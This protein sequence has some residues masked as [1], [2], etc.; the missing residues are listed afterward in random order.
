MASQLF[1]LPIAAVSL[2]DR[3]RQWFKSRVGVDHWQIPR[4]KAPC[5][6]VAESRDVLV[7]PDL[8]RHDCFRNSLLAKSG[9]RFYAGAPLVT[10]DGYGLGAM[11]VLGT[12]PREVTDEEVRALQDLAAMVMAQIELQHAFGRVDP[13]S[14][15]P[16]R[17]Q[18]SDDLEDAARDHPGEV[19]AAILVDMADVNELAEALRVV[20]PSYIDDLVKAATRSLRAAVPAGMKIYQIANTQYAFLVDSMDEGSLAKRARLFNLRLRRTAR[21]QNLPLMMEPSIGVAP[22]RLGELAPRDVLRAAHSAA[23][24]ARQAETTYSVYSPNMDAEHQRR[25]TILADMRAALTGDQLHLVYQP[26]IDVRS[27][28]C[29]AAEA[30]LR[31]RHPRLGEIPPGEFIPLIEQTALVRDVTNWVLRAA[32][33]QVA[34]WRAD[35]INLTVS[36]NVSAANLDEEGFATALLE[37]LREHDLPPSSL[38]LELTESA[39]IRNGHRALEQLGEIS[40]AGMEVAIDDFGTGYSSLSYLQQIP[41]STLKI[42]RSFMAEVDTDDHGAILVRAMIVMAH[43]LGYRVVAEGVETAEVR[44]WLAEHACDEMQGYFF[45][46]PLPAAALESWLAEYRP[47]GAEPRRLQRTG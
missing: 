29:I 13:V 27:G 22:F 5:A 28:S 45:S 14:G 35:G 4:E 24:E 23:Q 6:Q 12:E 19:R 33:A 10:R 3:D 9:V 17:N 32:V 18:F 41:A 31:W 2:T 38:E 46:R 1:G 8:L 36:V 20:G 44:D 37:L 30:L 25:F 43:D 21:S 15:L 16:T 11:C 42:D 26:R 7:V 47:E 39:L 40:D 34:K